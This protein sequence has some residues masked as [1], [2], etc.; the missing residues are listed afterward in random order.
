M[1]KLIFIL[2]LVLFACKSG[3][4]SSKYSVPSKKCIERGERKILEK[5]VGLFESKIQ[6][7]YP[8]ISTEAAYFQFIS[9]WSNKKL[10][11]DFFQ[12]SLEL[13]IRDLNL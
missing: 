1:K 11:V 13:K 7:K 6:E 4:D 9:D 10:P 8:E 12:D 3:K 2:F 5:A